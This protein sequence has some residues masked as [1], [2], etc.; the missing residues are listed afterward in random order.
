MT[1]LARLL[2]VLVAA[3]PL[4]ILFIVDGLCRCAVV[5]WAIT[6]GSSATHAN[7]SLS[8]IAGLSAESAMPSA[9]TRTLH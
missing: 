7:D 2:V 5:L 1:T 3:L 9:K 6:R 4:A 8:D